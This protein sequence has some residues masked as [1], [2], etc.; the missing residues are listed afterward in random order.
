MCECEYERKRCESANENTSVKD[1]QNEEEQ[2]IVCNGLRIYVYV[3]VYARPRVLE[4]LNDAR[5]KLCAI[6]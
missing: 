4:N 1:V 6:S 2:P 5:I 3:C